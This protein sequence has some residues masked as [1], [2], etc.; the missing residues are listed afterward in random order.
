MFLLLIFLLAV[1]SVQ[2]FQYTM[3][4]RR[5]ASGDNVQAS[6]KR[7][8]V[9]ATS[10]R[11]LRQAQPTTPEQVNGPTTSHPAAPPA[12]I[13][14][15]MVATIVQQVTEQVTKNL[16]GTSIPATTSMSDQTESP[17]TG[18]AV[19]VA[20]GPIAEGIVEATMADTHQVIAGIIPF[21][22]PSRPWPTQLFTSSALP[23]DVRV[24]DKTRSKI[25]ANEYIYFGQLLSSTIADQGYR[26]AVNNHGG[27]PAIS[28][29]P[30]SIPKKRQSSDIRGQCFNGFAGIYTRSV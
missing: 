11:S 27:T 14:D 17:H 20:P 4:Q 12:A 15:D 23:I 3:P 6:Q 25:W 16:A 28:L 24:P 13:P 22:V 29:E 8:R 18:R 21:S 19:P 7:S 26:L 2:H 10:T 9:G 1:T 5:T 30:I